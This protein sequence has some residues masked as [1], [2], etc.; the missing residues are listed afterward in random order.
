MRGLVELKQLVREAVEKQRERL[1]AISRWLYENP[2]LGSEEFKAAELLTG[3]LETHGFR[4]ER[5]LLAMP[6]AF[7]ASHRGR[8]GGPRIAVLA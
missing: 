6:T 1:Y 3:E 5:G 8:D 4:V 2:E 7:C